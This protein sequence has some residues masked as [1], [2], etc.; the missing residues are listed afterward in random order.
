[1]LRETQVGSDTAGTFSEQEQSCQVGVCKGF[2][3]NMRQAAADAEGN[4]QAEDQKNPQLDGALEDHRCDHPFV[5]FGGD[6][7]PGPEKSGKDRQGKSRPEGGIADYS[8]SC[9]SSGEQ[10]ERV[11]DRFKLESDIRGNS[12]HHHRGGQSSENPPLSVQDLKQVR[13][14]RDPFRPAERDEPFQQGWPEEE[15]E[16]GPQVDRQEPESGGCGL[17]HAAVKC[18]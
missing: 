13:Q 8:G 10:V 9:A 16:R 4:I 2:F 6:Q 17:P 1:M 14:A 18:P 15:D 5:P 12:D 7:A 11:P 3:K